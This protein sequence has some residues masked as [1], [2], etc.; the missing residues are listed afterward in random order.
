MEES[1]LNDNIFDTIVDNAF[2]AYKKYEETFVKELGAQ[3]I[4]TPEAAF[5]DGYEA[6]LTHYAEA[7]MNEVTKAVIL[8]LSK[9][10]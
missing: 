7:I 1:V 10:L 5:K 2:D 4:P 8:S 3:H 6:A 9:I